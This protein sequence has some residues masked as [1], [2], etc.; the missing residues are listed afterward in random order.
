MVANAHQDPG[1]EGIYIFNM[2]YLVGV[3]GFTIVLSTMPI[4][5]HAVHGLIFID[6]CQGGVEKPSF[7]YGRWPMALNGQMLIFTIMIRKGFIKLIKFS[8]SM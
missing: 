8:N 6:Y 7:G 1:P 2:A 4:V 3:A 5:Q